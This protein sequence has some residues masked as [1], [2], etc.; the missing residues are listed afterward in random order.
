M[1]RTS[2]FSAFLLLV[3]VGFAAGPLTSPALAAAESPRRPNFL[4]ILVDD[5]S[6]FDFRF[7]NPRSELNSPT[8]D[9]LAAQGMIIDGAYYMGG[10]VG[11]VCTPS[12]TMMMSG[13]TLWHAPDASGRGY[14]PHNN[15]PRLVPPDLPDHTLPAV[16]NR[17]GYATMRTCK[18]GNSYQAANRLFQVRHDADKR[19]A[20]DETGSAWHAERVLDYL[21]EREAKKD[22]RPFLI[23]FGFSHPHDTRDAKP[24]YLAKYGATNHTDRATPPPAHPKQPRLP[25]AY[26]P[27]HPFDQG[28]QPGQRDE[29]EASGVW[30][31]RDERTIRNELGRE[32]ACVENIDT[33]IDRVLRR[34]EAMGEL[35]N[36]YIFYTADNGIAIG[37]HGI[38]GKQILYEHSWRVPFIAR[39]PG[40]APGSRAP[41]NI[42]LLDVLATV[43]DLAGIA[44]PAT[45]EGVS[46]RAVLEGRQPA[47]RETLYGV[48]CGGT[49]PGIRAVRHGDWKLIQYDVHGGRVRESQLFNLRENPDELLIQHHDPAVVALTGNRP[50]PHQI[51]LAGDPRHAAKLRE[52]QERLLSEMRRFDDPFRLWNQPGDNLPV[53]AEPTAPPAP[54]A[55]KKAA[56]G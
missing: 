14:N 4:I 23:H 5:Q 34:L 21:Q 52:M 31:R 48:Y 30:E 45:N 16:F 38:Q 17:A 20:T 22:Q 28:N 1:P 2:R 24:E 25:L 35:D 37:R 40:I 11:G 46:F 39:G 51:N 53:P 26:L 18:P 41:G 44:A 7:Y 50:A 56:K 10:W 8:L 6:P 13:R 27:A 55:K 32:F 3:A 33:Q 47:I 19:G 43:C 36:T 54:A 15:N 9:R 49:R 42:Y 12:R 29:T